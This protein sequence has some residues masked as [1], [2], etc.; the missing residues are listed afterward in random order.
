M[1]IGSGHGSGFSGSRTSVAKIGRPSQSAGWPMPAIGPPVQRKSQSLTQVL[2]WPAG[3]VKNPISRMF[4]GSSTSMM[5][6]APKGKLPGVPG[7]VKPRGSRDTKIRFRTGSM[8]M[9]SFSQMYIGIESR[10]R[11]RSGSLTS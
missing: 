4:S 8:S 1:S 9:S 11:G 7:E 3:S 2:V 5:C 10:R 6:T